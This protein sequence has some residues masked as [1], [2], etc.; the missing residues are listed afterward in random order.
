MERIN[1]TPEDINRQ[2]AEVSNVNTVKEFVFD[3]ANYLN[4]R[5][6]PN[7][8]SKKIKVRLLPFF[9]EG[10]SPF[11]QIHT[12]TIKVNP[13]LSASPF[14]KAYVCLA[15]NEGLNPV[16][17][18]KCPICEMHDKM[19]AA[20]FSAVT[21]SEKA[22]YAEKEKET[23]V[24]KTWIVRCID[25]NHEDEG[26]KFWKFNYSYKKDGIWDK[27]MAVYNSRYTEYGLNIFDLY[28]GRDLEVTISRDN[29]G[30][31]VYQI[32]DGAVNTPL[33]KDENQIL[34]WVK[35]EKKWTDVYTVKP[36]DYLKLAMEGYVPYFDKENKKWIP[37]PANSSSEEE[38]SATE[39]IE[40]NALNSFSN[41][42]NVSQGSAN[43]SS[44]YDQTEDNLPF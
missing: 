11:F 4:T 16:L 1:I 26:V 35:D 44:V 36:Y 39:E 3:E 2:Y 6:K 37:K 28:E 38:H 18:N 29:T 23:R 24:R 32:V 33:S 15:N 19:N 13:E 21:E 10:G 40:M 30:K 12:H 34:E 5:L 31:R 41:F 14:G 25:R 9:P 8:V 17:G 22:K 27:I 7:E 20:M 42:G 43:Q